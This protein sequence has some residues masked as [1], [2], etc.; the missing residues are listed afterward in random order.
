M[1]CHFHVFLEVAACVHILYKGGIPHRSYVMEVSLLIL[2]AVFPGEMKA[3][4]V[5]LGREE[6][7]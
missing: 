3:T 2:C 1:M 5:A 7:S 4:A 6:L